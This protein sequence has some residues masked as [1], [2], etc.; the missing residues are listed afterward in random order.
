MK[1]SDVIKRVRLLIG[2][3]NAPYRWPDLELFPWIEDG[4]RQIVAIRPDAAYLTSVAVPSSYAVT[5]LTS[6]LVVTD[7]FLA[8]LVDYVASR[9][10]SKD[11]EHADNEG[12]AQR[13]YEQFERKV[14]IA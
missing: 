14:A 6:D 3:E 5:A 2:D 9:A 8:A 11:A 13:L 4:Q 7:S 12:A 10:M 1:A